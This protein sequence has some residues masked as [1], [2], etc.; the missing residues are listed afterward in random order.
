[1]N[2]M[3]STANSPDLALSPRAI[4]PSVAPVNVP[5]TL[6]YINA[7]KAESSKKT[8]SNTLNLFVRELCSFYNE[9]RPQNS[10]AL[11]IDS[12][13]DLPWSIV[14]DYSVSMTLNRLTA[15]GLNSS[16][17]NTYI[18]AVKRSA[19]YAF[20]MNLI[21]SNTLMAIKAIKPDTA[22][23]VRK[24]RPL[25][26]DQVKV[27]FH[28]SPTTPSEYRDNALFAL[29]TGCGLRCSE[30]MAVTIDDFYEDKGGVWLSVIGKG[31]KQRIIPITEDT[32][33]HIQSWLN[34]RKTFPLE[35]RT[36]IVR[37]YRGGNISDSPLQSRTSV[38]KI[39]RDRCLNILN[40]P[41][42]PHDLRRT[43]ATILFH[44]G[45]EVTVIQD[46]LGHA[47]VEVTQ[48][49]ITKDPAVFTQA[50]QHVQLR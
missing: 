26:Q 37:V 27:L 49:Y 31:N 7:L 19:D 42:S 22:Y 36:L 6:R 41:I 38:Y 11:S 28:P 34:L 12:H 48:R 13:V 2:E 45:V 9:N 10:Q 5:P 47:N 4:V 43:L 30:M 3:T 20:S 35:E 21:S 16:R 29:L 33:Y 17:I 25:E 24:G 46:I 14:D 32:N 50:M 44:H 23:R 15:N 1:M 8:M 18:S 40:F 39:V